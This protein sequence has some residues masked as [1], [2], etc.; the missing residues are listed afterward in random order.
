MS[1]QICGLLLERDPNTCH[2]QLSEC[3]N[4]LSPCIG[5]IPKSSFR[6]P[7]LH[8]PNNLLFCPGFSSHNAQSIAPIPLCFPLLS[9]TPQPLPVAASAEAVKPSA[10]FNSIKNYFLVS[11]SSHCCFFSFLQSLESL[12]MDDQNQ[13]C[14]FDFLFCKHAGNLHLPVSRLAHLSTRLLF[15]TSPG[16]CKAVNSMAWIFSVSSIYTDAGFHPWPLTLAMLSLR[17]SPSHVLPSH[18]HVYSPMSFNLPHL[19]SL[20]SNI[21][22]P[23]VWIPSVSSSLITF[24]DLPGTFHLG[25]ILGTLVSHVSLGRRGCP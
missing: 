6:L 3:Q 13:G 16:C 5:G 4:L 18:S 15:F 17:A 11:S 20:S 8:L 14:I 1:Q 19:P 9:P 23:L 10:L 24:P 21:P 12:P 2:R 7:P 25:C 22:C